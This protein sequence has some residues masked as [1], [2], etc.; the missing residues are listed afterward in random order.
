MVKK[1]LLCA[2]ILSV[3]SSCS[4]T[5]EDLKSPCV[6][7]DGSPCDRRPVNNAA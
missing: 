1:I 2:V 5:R 4:A 7:G 6:G 3:V